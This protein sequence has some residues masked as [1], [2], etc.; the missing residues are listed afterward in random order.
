MKIPLSWI[1]E[2]ID[3]SLPPEEIAK[4][5]TMAGLEVDGI[6]TIAPSFQGVIVGQVS[7]AEKHPNADKL[8]LAKV[9]DGK[10][11]YQVVCGAPNC[12]AGMRVAFAPIGA[13]IQE[14]D[15]ST[16]KIKHTKIRGVESFGMMCSGKELRIS[17]ESDQI[18]DLPHDLPLGASLA[19]FYSDVIFEIS[20]TPN[21]NHC[22]SV[23]GVV[24]ELS[25]AT[26]VPVKY[27]TA[28]VKEDESTRIVD[29]IKVKV[30]DD[31][32][33]PRYAC[34]V[35]RNVKVA[36]S[37]FWMQQRLKA[38]GF[39]PVNNV[40]DA[41]NYALL[42][43]GH[44]LHPFDLDKL[45]GKEIIVKC[46]S[47]G[48]SFE[49]LD[50]KMRVLSKEDL[51]ICDK[52]KPIAIAGVMGGATTEVSENTVNVLVESAYF[53]PR[54]IRKTSK[55]HGLQSEASKRFERG[56][57]PNGVIPAL[58]RAAMLIKEIGGGEIVS[59]LIDVKKT[60]FLEKTVPCRMSRINQL[61]GTHLSVSEVEDIFKRLQFTSKWDGKDEFHVQIPTYRVDIFAEVDLIE[62]VIRVY[63]FENMKKRT[64]RYSS[65]QLPHA[66]IFLFEREVRSRLIAQGLQEFLTCDLIGPSL[67]DIVK[68]EA[69]PSKDVVKVLNPTSIEQSALR[70]SMLPGL[71]QVVKYNIDHQN[72]NVSGFE[73]G[74]IHFKDKDQYKEQS[75]VGIV[76]SG[77][78]D[79]HH[80]GDKGSDIDF[81]D[82][83]GVVENLL[84]EVGITSVIFKNIGLKAFHSGRQASIFVDSLELGT[85]GEIHPSI[86]RRLDVTQ[87]I[88]FAEINLHDLFH[89]RS[90]GPKKMKPLTIYPGSDRDLTVT[91]PEPMPIE[92]VFAVIRSMQSPYLEE[93]FLLDIYRSDK[94]GKDIKNATFRFIYREKE[95]T[96]DQATV[97][98]EHQRLVSSIM[99]RLKQG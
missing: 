20:L 44:P 6:E 13:V 50:H 92:D 36:P 59:G 19:S 63:G 15:G 87:R 45:E 52:N 61:L 42:E 90:V 40:V 94:L 69:M 25:A 93:V 53:Q 70:T 21:L 88:F 39:R 31:T 76:L 71:L 34:R 14:D 73:V 23:I 10:E 8:S 22:S 85:I 5:L 12:R 43:M 4:I 67:I 81:Y 74:R 65:S 48:E 35:I 98:T 41:T 51:M 97:D 79:P 62:E 54:S 86:L 56:S 60:E 55:R 32:F 37:P 33:C 99:D 18:L 9:T 26:R 68:E 7:H 46:A 96:I 49:T 2:Y 28:Y 77:K 95:K 91:L 72:P 64:G 78:R 11:E 38:C 80:W 58:N 83:K 30:A 17:E 16:F 84:A 66:P 24:R 47:E 57:D 1:K 82:L 3:I 89:V 29:N 75:M 27:P